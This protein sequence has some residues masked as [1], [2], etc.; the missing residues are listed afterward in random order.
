MPS[1]GWIGSDFS[2]RAITD[3]RVLIPVP[4]GLFQAIEQIHIK[5]RKITVSTTAVGIIQSSTA[6]YTLKYENLPLP[7]Q[8]AL[9]IFLPNNGH[10]GTKAFRVV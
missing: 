1:I 6:K 7:L 9:Y 2:H 8:L 3:G 5:I 10:N 4:S